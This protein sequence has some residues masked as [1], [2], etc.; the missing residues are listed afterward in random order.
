MLH[1]ILERLDPAML[2][3]AGLTLHGLQVEPGN[4]GAVLRVLPN[5]DTRAQGAVFL[6]PAAM[7]EVA[8][9]LAAAADVIEVAE[10]RAD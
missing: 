6:D 3:E 10:Q 1:A 7:R 4:D 2:K 9:V 5:P 8:R